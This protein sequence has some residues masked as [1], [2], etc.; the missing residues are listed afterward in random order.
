MGTQFL[1]PTDALMLGGIR[2]PSAYAENIFISSPE[3]V[4]FF[5][6]CYLK[7]RTSCPF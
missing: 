1:S 3:G 2:A 4:G 7:L 5:K 6:V